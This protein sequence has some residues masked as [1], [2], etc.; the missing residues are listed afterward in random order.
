MKYFS[1]SSWPVWLMFGYRYLPLLHSYFSFKISEV[2]SPTSFSVNFG[3]VSWGREQE[4]LFF[5]KPLLCVTQFRSTSTGSL[6]CSWPRWGGARV[7]QRAAL[8]LLKLTGRLCC[9][10]APCVAPDLSLEM[11]AA[12]AVPVYSVYVLC[13][14]ISAQVMAKPLGKRM[15]CPL[16]LGE[17]EP[18]NSFWRAIS[19]CV[20]IDVFCRQSGMAARHSPVWITI[21]L[22]S[23]CSFLKIPDHLSASCKMLYGFDFQRCFF[24]GLCSAVVCWHC[25]VP[26]CCQDWFC[27]ALWNIDIPGAGFCW[28]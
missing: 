12:W 10:L 8:A 14:P 25:E 28:C 11:Q 1:L 21:E 15:T 27:S 3:G 5:L 19:L 7:S 6:L 4:N 26:Q 9:L 16:P 17:A 22:I 18:N 2:L 20:S 24:F 23:F 13:R